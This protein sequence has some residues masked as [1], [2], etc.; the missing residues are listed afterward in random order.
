[1]NGYDFFFVEIL[2][3]KYNGHVP[4]ILVSNS[5]PAIIPNIIAAAPVRI[6]S[7]INIATVTTSTILIILSIS[8]MFKFISSPFVIEFIY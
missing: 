6:L 8:P 2:K 4:I 5:M 1:M 7:K 3:G